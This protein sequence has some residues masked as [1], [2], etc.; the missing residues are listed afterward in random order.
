MN[1]A[2][3][4]PHFGAYHCVQL[5]RRMPNSS[6]AEVMAMPN[7][8]RLRRLNLR[9]RLDPGQPSRAYPC[10][11]WPSR[12]GAAQLSNPCRDADS[13]L[14]PLRHGTESKFASP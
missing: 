11:T 5:G 7:R 3:V 8:G 10:W 6:H 14:V 1:G 13:R 4:W 9:S 12:G 2:G